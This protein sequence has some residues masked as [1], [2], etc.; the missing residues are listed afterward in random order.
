M[1]RLPTHAQT[2]HVS[3][4]QCMTFDPTSLLYAPPHIGAQIC[5]SGT[6]NISTRGDYTALPFIFLFDTDIVHRDLKLENVLL[7]SPVDPT[8]NKM[9]IKVHVCTYNVYVQCSHHVFLYKGNYI[10]GRDY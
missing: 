3:I 4:L 1:Y 5:C 10:T 8:S 2:E 7:K 6:C 9:D